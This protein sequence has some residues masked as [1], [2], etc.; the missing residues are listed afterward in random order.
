MLQYQVL[1]SMCCQGI[2]NGNVFINSSWSGDY[3]SGVQIGGGYD[4]GIPI[5]RG[6][7]NLT[8]NGLQEYDRT[9]SSRRT[10]SHAHQ[11]TSSSGHGHRHAHRSQ[12]PPSSYNGPVHNNQFNDMRQI[13]NHNYY[14]TSEHGGTVSRQA[15][16]QDHERGRRLS[17]VLARSESR[18][19]RRSRAPSLASSTTSSTS[20]LDSRD[21]PRALG[22]Y[23]TPRAI[24]P[25]ALRSSASRRDSSTPAYYTRYQN[26]PSVSS[27]AP[28]ARTRQ[29]T[30][31]NLGWN[32]GQA[33]LEAPAPAYEN[34]NGVFGR[35]S[36]SQAAAYGGR[37]MVEAPISARAP[38]SAYDNC[39]VSSRRSSVGQP[40]AFG[41]RTI[42]N[43]YIS[44]SAA[45][46]GRPRSRSHSV[47]GSLRGAMDRL[48]LGRSS[49]R[50]A[51]SVAPS[52]SVS[53]VSGRRGGGYRY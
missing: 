16:R 23:Q 26:T 24:E 45:G 13:H 42:H 41:G 14:V 1:T 43:P 7:V 50:R 40:S 46:S 5:G 33:L 11:R 49:S 22:H 17:S 36:R 6:L 21:A 27:Y 51:A 20:S 30:Q 53:N 19:D 28:S 15:T 10:S 37:G 9:S 25:S 2:G 32:N 48:H 31:Y 47:T 52:E 29:N 44:G 18:A 4:S 3:N 12:H 8:I 34:R 39:G 38:P 35:S